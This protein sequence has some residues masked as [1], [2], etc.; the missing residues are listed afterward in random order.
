MSGEGVKEGGRAGK[1]EE[2]GR[3]GEGGRRRIS[4]EPHIHCASLV[5]IIDLS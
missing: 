2:E 5:L 3:R 1:E 4:A